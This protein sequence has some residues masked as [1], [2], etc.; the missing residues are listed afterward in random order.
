VGA[1]AFSEDVRRL[2][3]LCAAG[4][5][6]AAWTVFERLRSVHPTLISELTALERKE[7]A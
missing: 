2:E 6:S 1:M 3:Q 4:N 5:A 7:S